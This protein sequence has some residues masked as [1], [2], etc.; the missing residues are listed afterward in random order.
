MEVGRLLE[1]V[2]AGLAATRISTA[3]PGR[4]RIWRGLVD[5]RAAG[6]TLAEHE[7]IFAAPAGR[8]AALTQA[9]A[10]LH[11]SSTEQ[12][13]RDHLAT[14]ASSPG[15]ADFPGRER[16]LPSGGVATR[17]RSWQAVVSGAR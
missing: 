2:A 6:C 16:V 11:V 12:W 3:G 5:A 4:R 14:T 1:P 7:A 9:A 15:L 13:L 17:S 8:D 10:L